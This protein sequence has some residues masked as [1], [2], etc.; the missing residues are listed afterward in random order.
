M[1][2]HWEWIIIELI[3]LAVLVWELVRTRRAIRRDKQRAKRE[4]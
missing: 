4:G 1:L 2:G 3:V